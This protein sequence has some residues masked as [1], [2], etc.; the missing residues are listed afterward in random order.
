MNPKEVESILG[1]PSRIEKFVL[2]VPKPPPEGMRYFYEQDGKTI[3]LHFVDGK[4]IS[5]VPTW[6]APELISSS[7]PIKP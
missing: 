1:Q 7:Q 3:V 4:L 2:E 6:N 5:Q